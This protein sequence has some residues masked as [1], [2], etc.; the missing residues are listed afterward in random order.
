MIQQTL[1]L[2]NNPFSGYS[3]LCKS[4]P[5]KDNFPVWVKLK[6]KLGSKKATETVKKIGFIRI[7]SDFWRKKSNILDFV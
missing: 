4:L 7:L 6:M 3:K 2:V 1:R 5:F